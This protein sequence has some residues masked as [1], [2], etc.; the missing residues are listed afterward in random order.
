ME[1]ISIGC[2][3]LYCTT[4]RRL[5]SNVN[6]LYHLGCGKRSCPLRLQVVRPERRQL[7]QRTKRKRR[8]V[9]SGV[10]F[11]YKMST[12][13]FRPRSKISRRRCPWL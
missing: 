5:Y 7:T 3:L 13:F 10:F 6:D 2:R 8:S 4:G 1:N 11:G 9:I 12:T